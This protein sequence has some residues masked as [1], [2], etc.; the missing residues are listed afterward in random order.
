MPLTVKRFA[1]GPVIVKVSD[2][3]AFM[4]ISMVVKSVIVR[5]V[6]NDA[7]NTIVSALAAA[8][9]SKTACRKLPAPLSFVFVTVKV[10]AEAL[11]AEIAKI[12]TAIVKA[13]LKYFVFLF[14]FF[15]T[16]LNRIFAVV[17]IC[18]ESFA[19]MPK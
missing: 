19:E 13:F 14:I 11:I 16:K 10:A 17:G 12:K 15:S 8:F 7:S 9:A 5:G 6:L 4:L 2:V 3:L 18:A 1:P